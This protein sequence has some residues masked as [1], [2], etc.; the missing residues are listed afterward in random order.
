MNVTGDQDK[1][2]RKYC[3]SSGWPQKDSTEH[4]KYAGAPTGSRIT[5]NNITNADRPSL[6]VRK[7]GR[8]R[9]PNGTYGSVGGRLTQ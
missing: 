7:H 6:F 8:S 3:E 1:D 5:E 9:I 4:E 2:G